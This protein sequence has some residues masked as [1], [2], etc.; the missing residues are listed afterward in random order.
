MKILVKIIIAFVLIV[1]ISLLTI[2]YFFTDK[3]EAIIKEEANKNLNASLDF[4]NINLS[5]FTDFPNASIKLNKLSI[6][7]K[8]QF[9][10]DTLLYMNNLT[11]SVNLFKL[12]REDQ[13]SITKIILNDALINIITLEN[14]SVNYDISKEEAEEQVSDSNSSDVEAINLQIQKFIIN[15]STIIYDDRSMHF[16]S[17]LDG[18]ALKMKGNF[19]ADKT[20]LIL[21][22]ICNL[23]EINYEG[24]PLLSSTKLNYKAKIMADLE[25]SIFTFKENSLNLNEFKVSFDGNFSFVDDDLNTTLVFEAPK[26][27]FKSFLSLIPALYQDSFKDIIVKGDFGFKGNIKGIYSE[28][29]MPDF[30]LSTFVENGSI[31]YP[32]LPQAISDIQMKLN[33]EKKG[34]DLDNTVINLS[35]LALELGKNPLEANLLVKNPISDPNIKSNI[36]TTLDLSTLKDFYPIQNAES[37]TGK[38]KADIQL[39][40]KLSSI[41]KEEYQDFSALGNIFMENLS[42]FDQDLQKDIQIENAQINFSPEYLDFVRFQLNVGKNKLLFKGK[43]YNYLSYYLKDTELIASF[44]L[45]SKYLNLNDFM[46]NETDLSDTIA[47]D[48]TPLEIIRIPNNLNIGFTTEIEELIYD[49]MTIQNMTGRLSIKDQAIRLENLNMNI[50]ESKLFLSGLYNS[51]PE[52]P[53][54]D[55]RL[56][57]SNMQAKMMFSYFDIVKTYFPFS[58]FVEGAVNTKWSFRTQLD[59]EMSPIY[60]TLEGGG[61]ISTTK[62]HITKLSAFDDLVEDLHI[63][64]FKSPEIKPTDLKFTITDGK[65]KTEEFPIIIGDFKGIMGG[66]TGIDKSLDYQFKTTLPKNKLSEATLASTEEWMKKINIFNM[67]IGMPQEIPLTVFIKGTVDKPKTNISFSQSGQSIQEEIQEKAKEE[68]QKQKEEISK[69]ALKRANKIIHD[70]DNKAQKLIQEAEK[71]S[72][73]VKIEARNAAKK[74]KEEGEKQANK[75]ISEAKGKG[76]LAEAAAKEAAKKIKK[77]ANNQADNIISEANKK[78]DNIVNKAKQQAK[79]LKKKAQQEAD[80]ITKV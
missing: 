67:D 73:R 63:N 20:D 9:Q 51:K 5:L 26:N 40:G 42:Y 3:V 11:I 56:N 74:V 71:Q 44:K 55:M 2:P 37:Y 80:K 52:I 65:I 48:E 21:D 8:E 29:S 12:I 16:Y 79:N 23:N 68:I 58:E 6:V 15:G 31:K 77:E 25:N 35:Q 7:G 53:F 76:F 61:T 33:I 4:D 28:T 49:N 72:K 13:I 47:S 43:A 18:L 10:N 24:D 14:G 36:N 30:K 32:D 66:Y 75:L 78:A 17:K 27:S 50:D 1:I 39:E 45:N 62:L 22:I 70:A 41:E 34:G 69:E 38:L 60:N 57:I 19:S 54:S 46:P 59:N 64:Q